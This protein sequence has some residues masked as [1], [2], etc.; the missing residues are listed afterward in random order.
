MR[1]VPETLARALEGPSVGAWLV[2]GDEPLLVGEACDAIR[3]KARAAGFLGREVH[4][5]ERG[6]DWGEWSASL[7]A[8]SLFAEQ[9]IVEVRLM[10]PKPGIEGA[11][12]LAA[13]VDDP[14][15][16][17]L[18]LVITDKIEYADRSGAWVQAFEKRGH[19]LDADQ[20]LPEQLPGWLERRMRRIG[21]EPA[22]EAVQLLAER[23]E[24]NL[25]AAH[26]EIELLRLITGPGSVTADVVAD[27]V[28]NSAR[29]HV[30][31]LSEALLA[32]DTARTVRILDG[33][34]A[35]GDSVP[36]VL[37]CIAEEIRSVLQWTDARAQGSF[38]LKR[39]GKRRTTL[40]ARAAQRVPRALALELLT[41]AARADGLAKSAGK[42]EAWGE[43][44]RIAT[45]F[46]IARRNRSG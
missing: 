4:F 5:V 26:Q 20:L 18:L 9:R 11:R 39:G 46:C 12:A 35:D 1:L 21:L 7:R 30:F 38:R 2:A 10:S 45:E 16:D 44:T 22:P 32:G 23:C 40:L 33:L 28:A 27:S 24:G 13:A 14:S 6:F 29:Y 17:V 8:M 41:A 15:P 42:S 31:Q 36:L 19:C 34:A 43:V 37:W 25:V 3:A